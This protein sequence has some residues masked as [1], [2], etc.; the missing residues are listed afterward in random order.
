MS[1]TP[2]KSVLVFEMISISAQQRSIPN[3]PIA[4]SLKSPRVLIER[5][6]TWTDDGSLY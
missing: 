4:V 1:S 2:K 3:I 5:M 6:M